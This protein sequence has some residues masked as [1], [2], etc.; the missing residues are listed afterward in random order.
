MCARVHTRLCV[1]MLEMEKC[2]GDI[3]RTTETERGPLPV[4][5]CLDLTSNV[6]VVDI[7]L[8][9]FIDEEVKAQTG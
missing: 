3:Y 1:G 5:A 2:W 8:L 7:V 4:L 9:I 6:C